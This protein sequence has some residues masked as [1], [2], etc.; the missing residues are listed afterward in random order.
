MKEQFENG[1]FEVDV[2]G[3]VFFTDR[4]LKEF[5]PLFVCEPLVE[6]GH[7]VTSRTKLFCVEGTNMLSCIKSPFKSGQVVTIKKWSCPSEITS[8]NSII[9][10]KTDGSNALSSL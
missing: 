9:T 1:L 7:Q 5:G 3:D 6:V 2:N 8:K 4:G 10:I